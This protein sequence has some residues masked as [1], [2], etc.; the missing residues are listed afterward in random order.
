MPAIVGTRSFPRRDDAQYVTILGPLHIAVLC[1][2]KAVKPVVASITD[3]QKT[4]INAAPG[5]T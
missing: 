4:Q 2:T 5:A 3:D 1:Y